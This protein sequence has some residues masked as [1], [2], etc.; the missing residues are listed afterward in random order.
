MEFQ[1]GQKVTIQKSNGSRCSGTITFIQDDTVTV[2][3]ACG[4]VKV[5]K[6]KV[7]AK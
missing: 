6:S 4:K 5:H 2:R 3:S 7:F 1:I